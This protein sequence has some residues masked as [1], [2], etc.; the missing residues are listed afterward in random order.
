MEI[1]RHMYL[2]HDLFTDLTP[3]LDFPKQR[4][5]SQDRSAYVNM[6]RM[7]PEQ[8]KTWRAAYDPKDKAFREAKLTGRDLVRWKFQRYAKNYL[9]AIKGVDENLARLRKALEDQG[10]ADN[11]VFVYSSDQGFYIGDHGWYDKRWMYEE[12]L[13]MLSL[14][15]GLVLLNLAHAIPISFKTSTTHKPSSKWLGRKHPATCKALPSSHCSK[16]KSPTTGVNPSTTTTTNIPPTIRS[17]AT[18]ASAP[19]ATNSSTFTIWR[20]GILRSQNRP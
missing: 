12:S 18:T 1:D 16:A 9:R 7:T 5:P 2:D 19:N 14:F 13:K 3:D 10:L 4:L 20:M 15:L 11:T 6:K 8:L 17:P